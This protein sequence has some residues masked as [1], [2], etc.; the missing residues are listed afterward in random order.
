MWAFL[1]FPVIF[2][3]L[4]LFVFGSMWFHIR[5]YRARVA[6]GPASAQW[7]KAPRYNASM[8][9][10]FGSVFGAL[11]VLFMWIFFAVSRY[12]AGGL[13]FLALVGCLV[14]LALGAILVSCL[15]SSHL[16]EGSGAC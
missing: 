1:I 11:F 14:A 12:V 10:V 4:S 7:A 2:Y 3:G 6:E 9:A 15:P 8:R 16:R 13:M 5:Q